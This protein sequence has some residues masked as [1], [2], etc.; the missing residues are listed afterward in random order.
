MGIEPEGIAFSPDGRYLAVAVQ[1]G[2]QTATDGPFYHRYSKLMVYAL[3]G[4][5]LRKVDE[6]DCGVWNQ[7][8]AFSPDGRQIYVEN[9]TG[10]MLQVFNW[11]GS[12]VTPSGD[13]TPLDGGGAAIA[14]SY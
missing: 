8:I 14:V 9:M 11:N 3:N 4:F 1:N 10:G 6:T 5:D 13:S 2:S 12:K 7:G